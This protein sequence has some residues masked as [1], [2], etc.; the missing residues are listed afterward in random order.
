MDR[1]SGHFICEG[2]SRVRLVFGS[3]FRG[4]KDEIVGREAFVEV[5]N[6]ADDGEM[7]W[8]LRLEELGNCGGE[9]V[10]RRFWRHML[11]NLGLVGVDGSLVFGCDCLEQGSW[12]LCLGLCHACGGW[13]G[14]KGLG[15]AKR[16]ISNSI[17]SVEFMLGINSSGL[18]NARVLN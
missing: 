13:D 7:A 8:D 9:G 16:N 14:R 17:K 6:T 18:T 2:F 12:F 4:L 1:P 11:V 10:F 5:D 3:L 15:G